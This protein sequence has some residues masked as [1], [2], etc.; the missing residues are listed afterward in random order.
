LV[1][2][3]SFKAVGRE[4]RV[5]VSLFNDICDSLSKVGKRGAS[6]GVRSLITEKA[7]VSKNEKVLMNKICNTII[8]A[9][10]ENVVKYMHM[11]STMINVKVVTD[12]FL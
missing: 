8:E 10:T 6:G 5:S 11:K 1:L 12:Y 3:R 2:T 9:E 4:L 7:L